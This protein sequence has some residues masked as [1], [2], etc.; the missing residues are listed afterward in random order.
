MYLH[1]KLAFF[2]EKNLSV[3]GP[4]LELLKLFQ[5]SFVFEVQFIQSELLST[6]IAEEK[7]LNNGSLISQLEIKLQS[8]TNYV[9]TDNGSVANVGSKTG[10]Y[11][12]NK[13]K[14]L[15]N[16]VILI[17]GGILL[18]ETRKLTF[19]NSY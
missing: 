3:E 2:L 8:R 12:S 13:G 6:G 9:P 14:S 5:N 17:S 4:T 1:K 18:N 10:M 11:F 19:R 16:F 15:D 7:D